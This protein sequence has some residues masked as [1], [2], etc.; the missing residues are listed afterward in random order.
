MSADYGNP[1]LFYENFYDRLPC[2]TD[3]YA[4]RA[5]HRLLE[6]ESDSL[7]HHNSILEFGAEAGTHVKYVRCTFDSYLL[8]DIRPKSL[9]KAKDRYR[10][11]PRFRFSEEDAQAPNLDP[12]SFDRIIATCLLIHLPEPERA[13]IAW[14]NLLKDDGLLSVYVPMEGPLL[15]SVRRF[16]TEKVAKR[17]GFEGYRLMLARE[18]INSPYSIEELVRHVFRYDKIQTYAWPLP[19]MFHSARLATVFQIRKQNV[20]QH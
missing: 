19:H 6:C 7:V 4:T 17:L 20:V 5:V 1:E 8:T 16:T 11:D 10:N 15:R 2:A 14:R 3:N 18:H 12:E 13:L 9:I